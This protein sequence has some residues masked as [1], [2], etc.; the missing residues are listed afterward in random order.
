MDAVSYDEKHNGGRTARITGTAPD[1]NYSWNRGE[2]ETEA[3][4]KKTLELRSR[5]PPNERLG[6]A[7]LWARACRCCTAATSA[8]TVGQSRQYIMS[9]V[10]TMKCPGSNENRARPGIPGRICARFIPF[11][12]DYPV[13]ISTRTYTHY[14]FCGHPDVSYH[15]KRAWLA[16]FEIYRSVSHAG[17]YAC[18]PNSEGRSMT[19]PLRGDR[20]PHEFALRAAGENRS[21]AIA[22]DTGIEGTDGYHVGE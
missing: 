13:F 20:I 6:D 14:L 3:R 17:E 8:G 7:R 1:Y 21:W 10:R 22:L 12:K 5:Q 11:R 15:E 2:E 18:R 9:T 4:K 16:D 19:I